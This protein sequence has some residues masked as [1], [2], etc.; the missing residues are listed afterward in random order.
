[1][2]STFR[3]DFWTAFFRGA[4]YFASAGLVFCFFY[5]VY[6]VS[7]ASTEDAKS[8]ALQGVFF[9]FFALGLYGGFV[10][11]VKRFVAAFRPRKSSFSDDVPQRLGS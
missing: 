9:Y 11:I 5:G 10:W 4:H 3:A 7:R 2:A 8:A 1:M 6:A